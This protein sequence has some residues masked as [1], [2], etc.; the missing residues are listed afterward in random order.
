MEALRNSSA[1]IPADAVAQE[2]EAKDDAAGAVTHEEESEAGPLKVFVCSD[3][4]EIACGCAICFS[5]F[6]ICLQTDSVD[7][8]FLIQFSES[9]VTA[10]FLLEWC[11]RVRVFGLKW[12]K[13]SEHLLDTFIVWCPGVVVV[14]IMQ[15]LQI[16]AEASD[17]FKFFRIARMLRFVQLVKAFKHVSAFEDLWKLVRGLVSSGGT[18]ASAMSLIVFNLYVF[19]IFCCELIGFQQFPAD[20]SDGAKEAQERFKGISA[21]MLTL[22][23]FM[24]GDDSQGIMDALVEELPWIWIFLWLFTAMSSFVLLNLVTA[25]IVQQAMDMSKGDEKEMA[26]LRKRE[27][28]REMKELEEM[29]REIDED[30]SGIV[31]LAEFKEAF[32]DPAICDKFLMLGLKEEQAMELFSLLDTGGEGELDLSEF[33]QGMSQLKGVAKNKDMVMLTKGIERLGKGIIRMGEGMG[34][35]GLKDE[36]E[37]DGVNGK[38]EPLRS[39]CP[40]LE[41]EARLHLPYDISN[42]VYLEVQSNEEPLFS[43]MLRYVS[44]SV[45]DA[46]SIR[47]DMGK[48]RGL[49]A[50][51]DEI[52]DLL[53]M[54]K[55][56]GKV[57]GASRKRRREVQMPSGNIGLGWHS[58][59]F[60][61]DEGKTCKVTVVLQRIGHPTG[62]GPSFFS[63]LVLFVEGTDQMPLLK[64][65]QKAADNETKQKANRVSLWRFDTKYHFWSRISRRMAR[66]LDSIVLEEGVKRPLLDDLEWFLKDETR[67]FYAKHGIPYHRC[68]LL[69][70]EPGTGKTSF[71]NSVAGHIQR[72]L[73]FI[74]MDKHMTDDTFRNAMTQLPALSMVVLEDVDALFTNHREAD[75]NNSSLSFSGF[76]N[77]LDGLGAPDDV[78][79]FMTTNHPDKLDPAVM[80]PGRIDLKAE[81]KK[82]NKDVASKYFLTFYPGAEDAAA[83]FG[84]SVGGRISERKVSMAQLQHFFLACHRQGFDAAKAAEYISDFLFDEPRE[85]GE[86][87]L[88]ERVGNLR[89]KVRERL[90]KSED[91]MLR[92]SSRMDRMLKQT[93]V[94]IRR[95]KTGQPPGS[96]QADSSKDDLAK[97]RSR[98]RDGDKKEKD[99][100]EQK[101]LRDRKE[102]EPREKKE[103]REHKE[104]REHRDREHREHKERRERGKKRGEEEDG[105]TLDRDGDQA[106]AG[107]VQQNV[108]DAM[109]AERG[110]VVVAEAGQ[111]VDVRARPFLNGGSGFGFIRPDTGKVNDKDLYFHCTA[112][113]KSVPF[114]ELRVNDEVNYEAVRDDRKGHPT[115]KNVSL[116]NGGS[117]SKR[118]DSRSTSRRR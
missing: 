52:D 70:G 118:K 46:K 59:D 60:Q 41:Q 51:D 89:S 95:I 88:K 110:G 3:E 18:L 50:D 24:H 93:E 105:A 74:Q 38:L 34:L 58:F 49:G 72:N 15:P 28:E 107:R 25:V 1:V 55:G 17:L 103:K 62:D 13:D 56:K 48:G 23:R 69:H 77:C 61:W 19:A 30:G 37:N 104:P 91:E 36:H 79:I 26:I 117:S 97:S 92:L 43:Y 80:R 85:G 22:T 35:H 10:F 112:V 82:P 73:C 16:E 21:S 44:K 63:S 68:Y 111:M 32:K 96:G 14:W 87:K 71:M 40:F 78:V 101:E 106:V 113:N 39:S 86:G 67:T 84:T 90:Q 115:A 5:V 109:I 98:R 94:A 45:Q 64:L 114:D 65:C 116:K 66:S 53:V 100:K 2:V 75:H 33:M 27:Q 9:M 20:A 76:L 12:F 29:F 102:K 11:L 7:L 54:V 83:S 42:A 81:F 99:S 47:A 4:F 57:G 108:G 31:S 6:V 8:P